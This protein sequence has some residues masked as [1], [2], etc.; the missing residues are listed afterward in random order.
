M[1]N[2]PPSDEQTSDQ[3]QVYAAA[4]AEELRVA[5]GRLVRY[6]R[7][8]ADDLPRA[9][10][11][12][13]ARLEASGPQSIAR[14]ADHRGVRHQAMSRSVGELEQLGLVVREPDPAD[15]RAVLVRLT[16]K[17]H[18]AINRDRQARHDVLTA[19]ILERVD[20]DERALLGRLP[21]LLTKLYHHP[22]H[23]EQP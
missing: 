1:T 3:T 16:R 12:S 11:E 5:I 17:G 18:D 23:Q 21:A 13:L 22:D 15:G 10:A 2:L 7:A 6:T 20:D 19:A 8:Q 14:L 9:R 4:L